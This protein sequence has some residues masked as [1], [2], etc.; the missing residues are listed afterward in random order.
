MYQR[1]ASG[2]LRIQRYSFIDFPTLLPILNIS[3]TTWHT[4]V[5]TS[6]TIITLVH[7]LTRLNFEPLK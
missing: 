1:K 5:G 4:V 3:Q 7:E 6:Q 2:E